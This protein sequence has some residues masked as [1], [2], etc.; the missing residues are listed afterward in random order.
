MLRNAS[1]IVL[2]ALLKSNEII[3]WSVGILYYNVSRNDNEMPIH[4]FWFEKFWF[5]GILYCYEHCKH[6]RMH[7]CFAWRSY[8]EA[9]SRFIMPFVANQALK[10]QD[11]MFVRLCDEVR[12]NASLV[13]GVMM[14]RCIPVDGRNRFTRTP[15]LLI[16]LRVRAAVEEQAAPG[17]ASASTSPK[18]GLDDSVRPCLPLCKNECCACIAFWWPLCLSCR[19]DSHVGEHHPFS[20][21]SCLS[22]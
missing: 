5:I 10:A 3:F 15:P 14:I 19:W 20:Y 11:A 18:L 17:Q 8:V 12:A 2:T 7:D 22:C 1:R 4:W 13:F 6:A 9:A 16:I 21:T